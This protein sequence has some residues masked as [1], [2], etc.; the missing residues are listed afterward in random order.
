ME[1]TLQNIASIHSG[2]YARPAS[3][4]EIVYVQAKHFN[5]NGKL[6]MSL[7]PD[8]QMDDQVTRHLLQDEDILFSAKGN[9]NFATIYE[10]ENGPCVASS[11]FM[12]IRLRRDI[13]QTVSSE[14][15]AWYINHP[16]TQSWLKTNAIGSSTLSISKATLSMMEIPLPTLEKQKAILRLNSLRLLE[17]SIQKQL[18]DLKDNYL[19]QLLITSVK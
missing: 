2:I 13:K 3:Y 1:T 9:K 7:I 19:Q 17:Q 8:L 18:S 15:L 14:Y 12:I 16:S 4:G 10:K 5:E 6:N 11:T